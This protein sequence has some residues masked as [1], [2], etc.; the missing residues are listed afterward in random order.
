MAKVYRSYNLTVEIKAYFSSDI[1]EMF[2]SS[3]VFRRFFL[4]KFT[5]IISKNEVLSY[6]GIFKLKNR[7][8]LIKINKTIFVYHKSLII[9]LKPVFR[10]KIICYNSTQIVDSI[11]LVENP[12]L[13]EFLRFIAA[14]NQ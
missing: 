11:F 13:T 1:Y 7:G 5:F 2:P 9:L 4:L 8:A 12:V 3:Y 6:W 14:K 10:I